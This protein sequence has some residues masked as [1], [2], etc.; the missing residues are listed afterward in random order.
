[1]NFK[2]LFLFLILSRGAFALEAP[3]NLRVDGQPAPATRRNPLLEPFSSDSIWNTAIGSGARFSR[4]TIS[5]YW[6]NV[7]WAKIPGSDTNFI[8][9]TPNAP[10]TPIYY[11]SVGWDYNRDRCVPTNTTILGTV[12]MPTDF[13]IPNSRGNNSSAFL[14]ADGR[15]IKQFQPITRCTAGGPATSLVGGGSSVDLYGDGIRGTHG[16][17]GMSSL[18]GTIRVGELRPGQKGPPHAL[19]MTIDMREAF[20]CTIKTD[21]FRWPAVKADTGAVGFYGTIANNPNATN[22]AFKMGSLFAIPGS[23]SITSLGLQTEPARQLAWTLQ[24]YGAY[25]VDHGSTSFL[26]TTENGPA[27][28]FLNQFQSDYGYS[29]SQSQGSIASNATA[30]VSDVRK[31][32]SV[33]Q[34]VDNNSSTSIGGGGTPRVPRKVDI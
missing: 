34:I 2:L 31:I 14:L 6:P 24:N 10:S 17:S 11:S 5:S 26:F 18:G 25:V 13:I 29:F 32:I 23:V 19:S 8:F 20:L 15:T 22:T 30:W 3:R 28:N 1:M 12:P 27:G 16:G 21:C 33:L 7:N 9:L 4:V